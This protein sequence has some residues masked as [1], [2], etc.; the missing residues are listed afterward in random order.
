[1]YIITIAYTIS[2]CVNVQTDGK[3]MIKHDLIYLLDILNVVYYVELA[4]NLDRLLQKRQIVR[5]FKDKTKNFLI[6]E[7][8]ISAV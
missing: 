4:F 6:S 8:L 2:I 5:N 1:M 3:L 7:Y